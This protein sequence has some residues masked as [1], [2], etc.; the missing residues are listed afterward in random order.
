[1]KKDPWPIFPRFLWEDNAAWQKFRGPPGRHQRS[2]PVQRTLQIRFQSRCVAHSTRLF[3]SPTLLDAR[4]LS[5]QTE[6]HSCS[7]GKSSSG[8]TRLLCICEVFSVLFCTRHGISRETG[9]SFYDARLHAPNR[10]I[11]LSYLK[12]FYNYNQLQRWHDI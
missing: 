3:D 12:H 11:N 2:W 1:M 5:Q 7:R 6:V 9:A 8:P 4:I 10:Q